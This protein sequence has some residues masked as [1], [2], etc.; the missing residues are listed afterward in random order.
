MTFW[1]LMAAIAFGSSAEARNGEFQVDLRGDYAASGFA[2][3]NDRKASFT[4][5][6]YGLALNSSLADGHQ[7]I[8]WRLAYNRY[9]MN[10]SASQGAQSEKLQ[11]STFA[12]GLRLVSLG[13]YVGGAAL[14]V[15]EEIA[16]HGPPADDYAKEYSGVGMRIETGLNLSL[17]KSVVLI[18]AVHYDLRNL[19]AK[20]G[21]GRRSNSIFA[22]LGLGFRF[23]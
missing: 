13:L 2:I 14:Y 16:Y 9:R 20:D 1:W 11:G 21:S 8:A 23:E 5:F 6:G 17:S 19:R 3:D 22:G 18:P 10:N 15:R 4:G 7:G 12:V